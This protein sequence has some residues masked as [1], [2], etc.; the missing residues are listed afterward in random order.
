MK[1]TTKKY[2][3]FLTAC[4]VVVFCVVSFLGI[5]SRWGYT[6]INHIK[7]CQN[8]R[9]GLDFD[10]HTEITLKPEKEGLNLEDSE[11][12]NSIQNRLNFV[13]LRDNRLYVDDTNKLLTLKFS[14]PAGTHD[15]SA[16][17]I[18]KLVGL[19]GNFSIIASDSSENLNKDNETEINNHDVERAYLIAQKNEMSKLPDPDYG[20][21]IKLT[22]NGTEKLAN[23]TSNLLAKKS[24]EQKTAKKDA[25]ISVILNSSPIYSTKIKEPI[26]NGIIKIFNNANLE[27]LNQQ[28][29]YLGSTPLPSNFQL[30]S[31]S[32]VSPNAGMFVKRISAFVLAAVLI[33]IIFILTAKFK[34][35]GLI[36]SIC[37]TGHIAFI[38]ACFTGFFGIYPGVVL[39]FAA[40][41]AS[42]VSIIIGMFSCFLISFKIH[43]NSKKENCPFSLAVKTGAASSCKLISSFNLKILISSIILM[44]IFSY[45]TNLIA[46]ILQ[47]L[48]DLCE[49]Q[50]LSNE[51]IASVAYAL[52]VGSIG[53]L[54]FEVILARYILNPVTAPNF[55]FKKMLSVAK[56]EFKFKSKSKKNKNIIIKEVKNEEPKK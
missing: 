19:S 42:I 41:V 5:H 3:A 2:L 21:A 8:L 11:L 22:E 46:S 55:N 29:A 44:A 52:F 17:T 1:L 47:P 32:K 53:A 13:G 43:Q 12:L 16:Q 40:L 38:V 39:N 10:K 51:G 33:A 24:D 23:L 35:V 27:T 20:I 31:L 36:C 49:V 54:L 26:T 37:L 18:A 45:K 14:Q 4:L 50:M 25:K 7:G 30:E 15:F 6:I 48:Y 34:V 28:L 9:F 56:L